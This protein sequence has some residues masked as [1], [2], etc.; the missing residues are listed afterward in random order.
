MTLDVGIF[1]SSLER[2][3]LEAS[4]VVMFEDYLEG[5]LDFAA[6][7]PTARWILI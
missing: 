1:G 6:S 7:F 4:D 2:L 5:C 3:A